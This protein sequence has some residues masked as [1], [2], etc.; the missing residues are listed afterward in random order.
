MANYGET[1]SIRSAT[2]T[3]QQRMEAMEKELE[4]LKEAKSRVEQETA[5]QK[6]LIAE[7]DEIIAQL[8]KQIETT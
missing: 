3:E 2:K 8:K 4:E 1:T 7:K 5:Q 6:A